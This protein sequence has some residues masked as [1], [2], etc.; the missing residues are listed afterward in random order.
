LADH[1]RQHAVEVLV[2]ED[3]PTI[4]RNLYAGLLADGY[5]PRWFPH[6]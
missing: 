5:H 3:A 2:V 1:R 4:R 6:R